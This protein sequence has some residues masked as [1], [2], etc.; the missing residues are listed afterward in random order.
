ML[1]STY[2]ASAAS[3]RNPAVGGVRTSSRIE[4]LLI[5]MVAWLTGLG[6]VPAS[7]GISAPIILEHPADVT[8]SFGASVTLRV[9]A[10][11][12]DLRYEWQKVV[13]LG[14]QASSTTVV[15]T[16]ETLPLTNLKPEDAG[17]Y[18]V[19]VTSPG[20][21]V[22]TS[23]ECTI[24]F[25]ADQ[26]ADRLR[27]VHGASRARAG[28][29]V[30]QGVALGGKFFYPGYDHEAGIEL[31][32][33]DGTSAGTRRVKDIFPGADHG[34]V[35]AKGNASSL[36][37]FQGRVYFAADDGEQG[38]AL[39]ASDGTSAG[40][41]QVQSSFLVPRSTGIGMLF[42]ADQY[43]ADQHPDSDGS[44]ADLELGNFTVM[45]GALYFVARSG[46]ASAL[47]R[48]D[49]TT[50]GTFRVQPW[51]LGTSESIL[52]DF[53]L[54]GF[55]TNYLAFSEVKSLTPIGG[56][57]F[58][59]VG[60]TAEWGRELWFS[61]GTDAGTEMVEDVR[62][63]GADGL[64]A[65]AV[66]A[67]NGKAFFMAQD[68]TSGLEPW[69]SDGTSIGTM[70][71]RD[72]VPGGGSSL[73]YEFTPFEGAV[74]FSARTTA[75]YGLFRTDGTPL[76]TQLVREFTGGVS[77]LR[78][79]NVL[80]GT[81]RLFFMARE[82]STGFELWQT[83][84][85]EAGTRLV[86]DVAPGAESSSPLPLGSAG[87]SLYFMT[88]TPDNNRSLWMSDGSDA[89]TRPL[90]P[91]MAILEQALL[92]DGADTYFA[93]YKT[94]GGREFVLYRTQGSPESTVDLG[95]IP[96]AAD[97][98]LQWVDLG[99]RKILN[100]A[101][102][103]GPSLQT[104]ILV[105]TDGTPA[106]TQELA[107]PSMPGSIGEPV[108]FKDGILFT[109]MMSD[110]TAGLFRSDGLGSRIL[111]TYPADTGSSVAVVNG[112]RALFAPNT[113]AWQQAGLLVTDGTVEGTRAIPFAFRTTV[114]SGMA[115]LG[116]GFVVSGGVA[117]FHADNQGLY[118]T[119]DSTGLPKDPELY[120]IDPTGQRALLR[121]FIPGPNSG[122]MPFHMTRLD[123][124][125]HF[126][127]FSNNL[128]L[129]LWKTD[130]TPAGTVPVEPVEPGLTPIFPNTDAFRPAVMG[131]RLYFGGRGLLPDVGWE[132]WKGN[133]SAI[134][135]VHLKDIYTGARAIEASA[136]GYAY[137]DK[138]ENDSQPSEFTVVG[139][140]VFFAATSR[141]G[142]ELWKTDGTAAG[143]VMVKD[144]S[145]GDEPKPFPGAEAFG[146]ISMLFGGSEPPFLLEE[147]ARDITRP[148]NL[149]AVAG[150]LYFVARD[151]E[152]R[153]LYRSD[154]TAAGTLPIDSNRQ[155]M[156]TP[157]ELTEC[158]GRLYY[159]RARLG[160]KPQLWE[161]DPALNQ[162]RTITSLA[163]GLSTPAHLTTAAGRLYFIGDD[164]DGQELMVYERVPWILEHPASQTL[165][166]GGTATLKVVTE[167]VVNPDYQWRRGV[168]VGTPLGASAELV[169]ASRDVTAQPYALRLTQSGTGSA[170]SLP[171]FL[172]VL[173]PVT[174]QRIKQSPDGWW[175][176]A[177]PE[178]DPF[179]TAIPGT[180]DAAWGISNMVVGTVVKLVPLEDGKILVAGI[181]SELA[182]KPANNVGRLL[183][184]GTL[185]PDFDVAG[186]PLGGVTDLAVAPDGKIYIAGPFSLVN[187]YQRERVA[188]LNADGSLDLTFK[189]ELAQGD[190]QTVFCVLP[191][192]D[193]KVYVGGVFEKWGQHATVS[194]VRLHADGTPDPSF[195]VS[196]Q[197]NTGGP[198]RIG[199]IAY[200]PSAADPQ[201]LL[202]GGGTYFVEA[203]NGFTNQRRHIGRLKASS[204]E[205][206][207]TF[208]LA[209]IP[210]PPAAVDGSLSQITVL[211]SGKI[212][213]AGIQGAGHTLFDGMLRLHPGG[214]L[215]T[216][217]TS[218][219]T[220]SS[221]GPTI[222]AAP[223]VSFA[224]MPGGGVVAGGRFLKVQGNARSHIAQLTAGGQ[225][226][227]SFVPGAGP[228]N[229][230][231]R[232]AALPDGGVL[233]AG[234]FTQVDGQP[235]QGLARLHGQP[236]PPQFVLSGEAPR[237]DLGSGLRGVLRVNVVGNPP[238]TVTWY[239]DD[240]EVGRGVS[241]SI[242]KTDPFASG[243]YYAVIHNP[244]GA[245]V[246]EVVSVAWDDGPPVIAR[247]PQDAKANVLGTAVFEVAATGAVPL[248]YQ[249]KRNGEALA[250]ET[251]PVLRVRVLRLDAGK[252]SYSVAVRNPV[253][254]A[255]S[256][257]VRI[258][259]SQEGTRDTCFYDYTL[260]AG[261]D[262]QF[263]ECRI[264]TAFDFPNYSAAESAAFQPNGHVVVVGGIF[265][266][267]SRWSRTPTPYLVRFTEWGVA[268]ET[269]RQRPDG[270]VQKVATGSDSSVYIAGSFRN[271]VDDHGNVVQAQ[272]W[273]AKFD[274]DMRFVPGFAP[275]L[276]PETSEITALLVQPDGKVLIAG[277]FSNV[278]GAPNLGVAR[279]LPGGELDPAFKSGLSYMNYAKPMAIA[280]QSTGRI[281]LG[282]QGAYYGSGAPPVGEYRNQLCRLNSD[283]SWDASFETAGGAA[284]AGYVEHVR[285]IVVQPD[286]RILIAGAIARWGAT[287]RNG[288]A[289]LQPDGALD[290]SFDYGSGPDGNL[291]SLALL[292]DGRLYVVGSFQRFSGVAI[293]NLVRL[294]ADG[295]IDEG[296]YPPRTDH[297]RD[298]VTLPDGSAFLVGSFTSGPFTPPISDPKITRREWVHPVTGSTIDLNSYEYEAECPGHPAEVGN[299]FGDICGVPHTY[300][301]GILRL[302]AEGYAPEVPSFFQQPDGL[303]T[304]SENTSHTLFAGARSGAFADA[305][306]SYQWRK[307][308]VPI[309]NANKPVLR[310][311]PVNRSSA[312]V[313][314][315]VVSNELGV[316]VSRDAVVEVGVAA[317]PRGEIRLQPA[318][319]TFE[320]RF[321]PAS[322]RSFTA[323]DA[324]S[325]LLEV[326]DDLKTWIP[327]P[328][329]VTVRNGEL[330]LTDEQAALKAQRFYRLVPKAALP[331]PSAKAD[332]TTSVSLAA[333]PANV[334]ALAQEHLRAF[335]GEPG[336]RTAEERR[337]EHVTLDSQGRYL[338]DP[339][340]R[341]GSEP[342]YVEMKVVSADDPSEERGYLVVSLT[343]EDFPVVEFATRGGTKTD[344]L[345]RRASSGVVSKFMRFSP[346]YWAGEDDFGD[347][348]VDLGTV[349]MR[350]A[351][352]GDDRD[353]QVRE[354]S[355]DSA[356]GRLVLPPSRPSPMVPFANYAELREKFAKDPMRQTLRQAR[357]LEAQVRWRPESFAARPLF[358]IKIGESIK[359]LENEILAAASVD[360]DLDG[361]DGDEVASVRL[362]RS[363]G[364]QLTGVKPGRGLLR[365]RRPDRRVDRY[366]I[367]VGHAAPSR[368]ALHADDC[369]QI[370]ESNHY[371][372][373]GWD[374]DQ[375]QYHQM[376]RSQWCPS[377]GCGPTALAMLLGW[378]DF[379]GV[380]SAFYRLNSGAGEIGSFR[381]DYSSVRT[382]DAPKDITDF[383]EEAL[384]EDVYDDLHGLCNVMCDPFGDGGGTYPDQMVSAFYEYLARVW[385]VPLLSPMNEFGDGFIG[386]EA[387]SSWVPPGGMTD[388]EGGG[389]MVANGIK[390]GRPGIIGIGLCLCDPPHYALAF[391]YKRLTAYL[392]CSD[393]E[394]VETRRFF[395]VNMGHGPGNPPEWHVAEDVWFG[396]TANLWQKALPGPQIDLPDNFDAHL[397]HAL[398]VGPKFEVARPAVAMTPNAE[399]LF[400]I[401]SDNHGN[402][403][404]P[405]RRM[406]SVNGGGTFSTPLLPG[407]GTGLFKSGA[408]VV[409][410]ANGNQV[411]VFGLGT[412]QRLW[413]ASSTDGGKT[414]PDA[415]GQFGP[416]WIFN[417]APAAAASAGST[418]IHVVGKSTDA[419]YYAFT[420]IDGGQTWPSKVRPLGGAFRSAPAV[421][422]SFDGRTVHVV[423]L[424]TDARFWHAYSHNRGTNWVGWG[425]IGAGVFNSAPAVAMNADGGI[426]RVFGRGTDYHFWQNVSVDGGA[427]WSGWGQI[428]PGSIFSSGPSVAMEANGQEIRLFGRGWPQVVPDGVI[429]DPERPRVYR[430]VSLDGGGTWPGGFNEVVPQIE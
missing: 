108:P 120:R 309:P 286:D 414:W 199:T 163:G 4:W 71:L 293:P 391:G 409:T 128:D 271:I 288:L 121:S 80:V 143:T 91:P 334:V 118:D 61:D 296:Y 427:T 252:D 273:I 425:A 304:L 100:T 228:N 66:T 153:K 97:P 220:E 117:G 209:P 206:D 23:R 24:S 26:G 338:F 29:P 247:P 79:A 190:V 267:G 35:V 236:S 318:S 112:N 231:S 258:V 202:V 90:T 420:S 375:R 316:V 368:P 102:I 138:T 111:M 3:S 364:V 300:L 233:I 151:S 285:R 358:S 22:A 185:D 299:P 377:V 156:G 78:A 349:P 226:D 383:A 189:T 313:Y 385:M 366:R 48:T 406:T 6:L 253:F 2:H 173:D 376:D 82:T 37:V 157:R 200:Y 270:P 221:F 387:E 335:I 161:Y 42:E 86:K 193:G 181:F 384:M 50:V 176:T 398:G 152:G 412:D 403:P 191:T 214:P 339:G 361:A 350:Q 76:G 195:T 314:S 170:R 55:E 305:P 13:R 302:H 9:R 292:P 281:L 96:L 187:G 51:T 32:V 272:R 359:V 168:G 197:P 241:L 336:T 278:N 269:S 250:G 357:K 218:G 322:G 31:W 215:D 101:S 198:F 348:V 238:P 351:G 416:V 308:G 212:L 378:W 207:P 229:E 284:N 21:G 326:T 64:L 244:S 145:T 405:F 370:V 249:W 402:T 63:S 379:N 315:V 213:V 165:L 401:E 290:R 141:Q 319:R 422:T 259:V 411:Q 125:V 417:S 194:L 148:T 192:A 277:T 372:G 248:S 136:F 88:E 219:P 367:L 5:G 374:Q 83:D 216:N 310:L 124:V 381:F 106:G 224:V 337:W 150:R 154:G 279:L 116:D 333:L 234:S 11:G 93:L 28:A 56:G 298:V 43:H 27:V 262:D 140:T 142:R 255:E 257:P 324:E 325:F 246:T 415:W 19:R 45:G 354:A 331:P 268:T 54:S 70:R 266:K 428:V 242:D 75:G 264:P 390:Q 204:G 329:A 172:S 404:T 352:E 40:T 178:P 149:V 167:G 49:G 14:K 389:K 57:R 126:F 276:L 72:I 227:A 146:W 162:H 243:E 139:N 68:A 342:A 353:G 84:G 109:A 127:T 129:E 58:F 386:V 369:L 418:T 235:R 407:I 62:G 81:G 174:S 340:Y 312:G 30:S 17:K 133:G 15:G 346:A 177:S 303:V 95:V 283:G 99:T 355:F 36:G 260:P 362:L 144:L 184:D 134:G 53:G 160:L 371:A 395:Y 317:N 237:V 205:W 201:F 265:T 256:A 413:R 105:V 365:V 373:S 328:G 179:Q 400:V 131:N 232:V 397:S 332:P 394:P 343:E 323:Q 38:R 311:D 169:V 119:F 320:W 345:L 44:E 423:G 147:P 399:K 123:G 104:G 1:L 89:G 307:D 222:A 426:L 429:P 225:V 282:G 85:T 245:T 363:G 274:A 239:R 158:H 175:A 18:R 254:Q 393:P 115:A 341:E 34:L 321:A 60:Q 344:R 33:T 94:E 77:R 230:V 287:P 39:W 113:R 380:P 52:D 16:R 98:T 356:S 208:N 74:Y 419:A 275:T 196:N 297:L 12:P 59:F 7:R 210:N 47:W 10:I 261:L 137:L 186:G 424:G 291:T 65:T 289:R 183:H 166:D 408:A 301:S 41:V 182:G 164:G 87:G 107:L 382:P 114:P 130:G 132:L 122:G 69:V 280:L 306:L 25:P 20:Y 295:T 327:V 410:A 251:N 46:G 347:R 430:A 330:V 223:F 67:L 388:W 294:N 92:R 110:D 240:M 103:L 135:T 392:G 180:L 360:V 73:A 421:A 8:A 159:V 211:P 203:G 188:R 217:F 396:L 263:T 171:A 155:P